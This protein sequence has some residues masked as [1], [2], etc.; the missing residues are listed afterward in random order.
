M[1]PL[2]LFHSRSGVATAIAAPDRADLTY[3][4]L[5]EQI[6]STGRALHAAGFER[7]DRVALV[8]PNGPE[9]ATAFLSIA[10]AC[11][12]A[13]LNPAY[14]EAEFDFY[15]RDLR[16]KAI[17]VAEEGP[18][19]DA[20]CRLG[21]PVI[22]LARTSGDAAGVF[23]LEGLRAKVPG[24]CEPPG[25][26]D[27]A[28]LLHTSGTT[29]RPKLV[30]LTWGNLGHSAGNISRTLG[31]SPADRCLN[32]M[33][34]FHIHGLAAVLL[35]SL[36]S[37]ASV[38]CTPGFLATSFFDWLDAFAPTWYSAVP[39]M[40]Q[41]VLGRA[42][43]HAEALARHR[44]RFIRS[45][46]AALPVR[47]LE[48]LEARFGVPV[49]EAYGMTE[50]AHQMA[51][52][53]LPPGMRKPGSAG[54]ATGTEIAVRD[55]ACQPLPAGATGHIWIAGPN[56]TPGYLDNPE[57]NG[58]SFADGWFRTGDLGW[59]D[60]D[61]YLFLSGRS[62]E[63][64]NRGGEKISPREVDEVLMRHASVGQCLT[65]ALPDSR[66]GEEVGAAV[67]L[68]PGEVPDEAAIQS[69][70]AQLLAEFKVPRRIYF[71]DEIPAGPTGKPQRIGLA[72]RLGIGE[73][74]WKRTDVSVTPADAT[75]VARVCSIMAE[76]LRI[77]SVGPDTNFFD[78]GGDSLLGVQLLARLDNESRRGLTLID[79][80]QASTPAALAGV[81]S[82]RSAETELE[83]ERNS[84]AE[85]MLSF[86]QKRLWFY[87]AYEGDS[88]A[89]LR[90]YLIEISGDIVSEE[91]PE[92]VGAALVRIVE[93]HEP[94]RTTIQNE[95][96]NPVARL[97]AA[98]PL[99]L[100]VRDWRASPAGEAA[101]MEACRRQ[102][103]HPFRL[104]TDLLLRAALHRLEDR[105]WWLLVVIHHI[106]V[107][108]W[109]AGILM[110]ELGALLRGET[111][112]P[113]PVAYS[114]YARWEERT[115]AGASTENPLAYWRRQLDGA[116]GVLD[117]PLD[118]PRPSLPA[119]H[120]KAV[121]ATLPPDLAA[122]LRGISR[123]HGVT[124]FMTLLAGWKALLA[125]LCGMTDICVGVP[126]AGRT[127]V[128]WESLIGLFKNPL[129]L[130]SKL[131]G[132]PAFRDI[133]A[134]VRETCLQAW[135]H[136]QIP[137]DKL[138]KE[139]HPDRSLAH[140]P[141]FQV[142]F[143]V[144]N[145]PKSLPESGDISLR[146]VEFDLDTIAT[147]LS[148][149]IAE[150]AQGLACRLSCNTALFR[151]RSGLRMLECFEV[152]LR[153][154]AEAP[155]TRLSALPLLT[156]EDRRTL[157]EERI[158]AVRPLPDATIAQLFEEQA[159]LRGSAIALLCGSEKISYAA[160][161]RSSNRLA[162][163]FQSLGVGPEK[164]AALCLN[165]S[166]RWIEAALGVL[167]AGGAYLALDSSDPP[168]RLRSLIEDS[169]AVLI[170]AEDEDRDKFTGLGVPVL[171]ASEWLDAVHALDDGNLP[172]AAGPRS[173]MYALF[174][175]G[176]TGQPK[177]VAIEHRQ[178]VAYLTCF[179]WMRYGPDETWL[180]LTATTFDLSAME[181][182]G[183]L[184]TG[185]RVAI[186]EKDL[187]D[188]VGLGS[189]VREAGVTS[190][191]LSSPVF[192][193]MIDTEPDILRPLRLILIGGEALSAAH[194]RRGLRLLPDTELVNGYGP[195]ETTVFST[196][197]RIPRD[198]DP[199]LAEIPIGRPMSNCCVYIVDTAGRLVPDG[200]PGELWI[201]GDSVGRGYLN[202]PG[203]TA[204][205]FLPNPFPGCGDPRVYRTGDRARWLPGGELD[206]M[207]RMD[208]QVKVRGVRI[209]L[210]EVE[211]VLHQHRSVRQCAV[212]AGGGTLTGFVELQPGDSPTAADLN[213]FLAE[214]LPGA[215]V[216][217]RILFVPSMPLNSAGKVDRPA[218]AARAALPSAGLNPKPQFAAPRN[219]VELQLKQIWE[220]ILSVSGIGIH[221]NFFDLGGHSL[222]AIRLIG[223]VHKTLHRNLA[224]P[225]FFRNPTIEGM[226]SVLQS[227]A[228]EGP[229]L[230]P[231]LPGGSPGNLFFLDAGI[232]LCGMAQ[233]LHGG[234]AS[235][236][237]V[238]P[239]TPDAVR[240]ATLGKAP[241]MPSLKEM[242]AAHTALVQSRPAS[243]PCVLAAYSFG[244]MLAFEVAHQLRREGR[245]V[246]MILL[247]DSWA[248]P[249]PKW[250]AL[251][252]LALARMRRPGKLRPR[253][254]AD[255]LF[256]GVPW[257]ILSK[258]FRNARRN[259]TYRPLDCRA[260]LIRSQNSDLA[261]LYSIDEAL[262]WGGLF[263]RGLEI[264]ETPGDHFSMFT[265]PHVE[266]LAARFQEC[267]EQIGN[268]PS[269]PA[270]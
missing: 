126:V 26:G 254:G 71:L 88:L 64:V 48:E 239:L 56:V 35:A 130:R 247:L 9:A 160:L 21:I 187:G 58:E 253:G 137:F 192:N 102:A 34:L 19:T 11:V 222:L 18:V 147:D 236:A 232:Q 233:L 204:E 248:V 190:C 211:A 36:S 251:K 238:V 148:L 167:K 112:A 113:L 166:P 13:P 230:V 182:W 218:L 249:P 6:A 270:G 255:Q 225:Q 264:V 241:E 227:E 133:L 156:G 77:E 175:S 216:P 75:V 185:G 203:L 186:F 149:E 131:D 29:S 76:V 191:F 155:E 142:F 223:E 109:S 127:R 213:A 235:F 153:G 5:A 212:T 12:C 32:V 67:V 157:L 262:G 240:A 47:V 259:Y 80:F 45:S 124:L 1:D 168:A 103:A 55:E 173:L 63:I 184:T 3:D 152:L 20:A 199:A 151:E 136:Q 244:G 125:R 15:L 82:T 2:P 86:G 181:I 105:R 87:D 170:L 43:L 73:D 27:T 69:F 22:Q 145:L 120:G 267:L 141:W 23:R 256:N 265:A 53:P 83:P 224:I 159:A 229:E 128:E 260:V 91:V 54:R 89:Y 41:A 183:P 202:R 164:I 217:S 180:Q 207:G 171:Y 146:L 46:S 68:R 198:L 10:S 94:L 42:G 104:D 51:S 37:G 14:R 139:L 39:T 95:E 93:R 228:H 70:A 92:R 214:R 16:P 219:L 165:R 85:P 246:S 106:A 242:A 84:G 99:P 66:L 258:V 28:L 44:L 158:P 150:T 61:G 250:R 117:L 107:D 208:H 252:A 194:V 144:R 257:K 266:T 78:A 177:A 100:E 123:E 154:A 245:E 210:G 263:T 49:I 33:P 81:L 179:H 201:G 115:L 221:D 52:N 31:L 243:G 237:T 116:P 17:A 118:F 90:P 178:L 57:A 50:A 269:R 40:H 38:V 111:L 169:G 121:S 62:K 4:G 108:G 215:M 143:Q 172:P 197:F 74:A 65:F 188:L 98:G 138:V 129:P 59:L 24:E 96:G 30:P 234:P 97:R 162:R 132:D 226:A 110:R 209:E 114:D 176:T 196:G 101:V 161:N 174:T 134:R 135:N 79:L 8:V 220:R 231:L 140:T 195:T 163:V 206:F 189:W 60:E 72:A 7:A 268:P 200:L 122:S 25:P 205:R 193:M 261:P 119:F